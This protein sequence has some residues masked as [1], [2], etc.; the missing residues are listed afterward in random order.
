MELYEEILSAYLTVSS[1]KTSD[2]EPFH[3]FPNRENE[4]VVEID[5]LFSKDMDIRIDFQINSNPFVYT[6]IE[7]FF[8]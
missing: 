4:E 2:H 8:F 7:A 5:E 6:S 1:L 3:T